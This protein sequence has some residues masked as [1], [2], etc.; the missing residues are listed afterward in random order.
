MKKIRA[1]ITKPDYYFIEPG[2]ESIAESLIR[3]PFYYANQIYNYIRKNRD[4]IYYL[5]DK[6]IQIT[7]Q[8][9]NS[10]IAIEEIDPQLENSYYSDVIKAASEFKIELTNPNKVVD[11]EDFMMKKKETLSNGNDDEK[12]IE[13][14]RRDVLSS[15]LCIFLEYIIPS[16]NKK[17]ESNKDDTD[18]YEIYE[19]GYHPLDIEFQKNFTLS[20]LFT[21]CTEF[22]GKIDRNGT[23]TF[24]INECEKVT[25]KIEK[26]HVYLDNFY[27][28]IRNTAGSLL[29]VTEFKSHFYNYIILRT[30]PN[31]ITDEICI[32][33]S[34][35]NQYRHSYF[36]FSK[37][38]LVNINELID[39]KF[40]NNLD[41]YKFNVDLYKLDLDKKID[42]DKN[43]N[44]NKDR[45]EKYGD[46][47]KN[48]DFITELGYVGVFTKK[49]VKSKSNYYM[50]IMEEHPLDIRL[51]SDKQLKEDN[52][53]VDSDK[54]LLIPYQETIDNSFSII[55]YIED[56][57]SNCKKIVK[58]DY[59]PDIVR[60]ILSD[61]ITLFDDPKGKGGYYEFDKY[62]LNHDN[63]NK[64]KNKEDNMYFL[65]KGY[66]LEKI[67]FL[68][69]HNIKK[70][71]E[72]KDKLKN[73]NDINND[74]NNTLQT[75]S[76]L[77]IR[78]NEII[79]RSE[80]HHRKT[81]LLTLKDT[82]LCKNLLGKRCKNRKSRTR[83]NRKSRTR[84]NR[85][86]RTRKNRK[87]RTRK[88]RKSRTRK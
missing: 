63:K 51:T 88:N 86:P 17:L 87:S 57:I 39:I 55:K 7:S 18:I 33:L 59:Y 69:L 22:Q 3:N 78:V 85:K 74:L 24:T 68:S 73:K 79:R 8:N 30:Y 82:G 84:K 71:L 49:L 16:I 31:Y 53:L 70:I 34:R 41:L 45:Y 35:H 54:S 28:K 81:L 61:I 58:D 43:I 12:V 40:E 11:F 76:I 48:D 5:F 44:I 10:F 23:H 75:L 13:I 20:R 15:I 36:I 80:L 6:C 25:T 66:L 64:D 21:L 4:G 37:T 60:N 46:G 1:F 9:D 62:K 42:L 19:V 38:V 50:F 52:Y 77:L 67:K 83:K 2:Y 65:D 29:P 14:S 47:L 32:F 56:A 72:N 26:L 27:G